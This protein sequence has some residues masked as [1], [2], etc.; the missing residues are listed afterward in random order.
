MQAHQQIACH[1]YERMMIHCFNQFGIFDAMKR[2]ECIESCTYFDDCLKVH[3]HFAKVKR[4][5]PESLSSSPYNR[6][7]PHLEELGI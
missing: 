5:N 2:P 7:R 6:Y 3:N 1:L 4:Y